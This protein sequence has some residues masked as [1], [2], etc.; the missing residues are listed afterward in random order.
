VTRR[1]RTLLTILGPVLA[2]V[3][4]WMLVLSP[5]ISDLGEAN[6]DLSA[7]RSTLQTTEAKL[8]EQQANR[9]QLTGRR[10]ALA[11]AGRAVP[12]TSQ[13]PELL[14]Q[15]QRVAE[16]SGVEI[17]SLTPGT[18]AAAT[19]GAQTIPLDLSI[20]GSY[21][22]T[23]AFMRGLDKLVRVSKSTISATGRLVSI[24]SVQLSSGDGGKLSGSLTASI[25]TF[26]AAAQADGTTGAA[27]PAPTAA[28]EG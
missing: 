23:Q 9:S 11:A 7:A 10:A 16:R 3:V 8:L 20:S 25:Y 27:T 28:T 2:V 5:K 15:L 21:G 4:L 19:A 12:A 17:N 6:D 24:S 13:I 14:R 26:N 22:Q 18:A 1:D